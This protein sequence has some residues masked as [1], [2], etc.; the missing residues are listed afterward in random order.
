MMQTDDQTD[1]PPAAAPSIDLARLEFPSD[2]I[3]LADLRRVHR[4]EFDTM[5]VNFFDGAKMGRKADDWPQEPLAEMLSIERIIA[6]MAFESA[7]RGGPQGSVLTSGSEDDVELVGTLSE[8]YRRY[9]VA[10]GPHEARLLIGSIEEQAAKQAEHL[11]GTKRD[12]AR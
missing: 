9:G 1:R 3:T 12:V 11:V 2:K 4:R 6:R 7:A 10:H 8:Y 5:S